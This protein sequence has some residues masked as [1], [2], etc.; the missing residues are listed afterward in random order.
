MKIHKNITIKVSQVKPYQKNAKIH[1]ANQIFQIAKSIE[2]YG[3]T[4]PLL[5]DEKNNLIA[6]HGRLEAL[7]LLI[8]QGKIG[9][10]FPVPAI[11]ITGLSDTEKKALVL[12]DNKIA[13]NSQWDD[14][15]LLSELEF[16]KN[17]FD[18]DLELTGFDDL[19]FSNL[20]AEFSEKNADNTLTELV[21]KPLKK[22]Y[23]Y[24]FCDFGDSNFIEKINEV[25]DLY[26]IDIK[27]FCVESENE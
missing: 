4:N 16:I 15:L 21:P 14:S 18:F 13:E 7:K 22:I 9:L 10:D 24:T 19:E 3:F 27:S 26:G 23:F 6:G 1:T 2:H 17:N 20:L 11:L 5:I 12:A 25:R 8:N